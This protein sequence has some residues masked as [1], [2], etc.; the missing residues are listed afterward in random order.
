MFRNGKFGE[1]SVETFDGIAND[2]PQHVGDLHDLP[3]SLRDQLVKSKAWC[4]RSVEHM[5]H[6]LFMSLQQLSEARHV[7]L[8]VLSVF[9]NLLQERIVVHNELVNP[10]DNSQRIL[11][12]TH[13]DQSLA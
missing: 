11:H 2:L 12:D 4:P 9:I 6:L 10:H 3:R 7:D 13:F 5:W 1:K 8:Q